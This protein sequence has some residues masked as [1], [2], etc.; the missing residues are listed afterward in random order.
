MEHFRANLIAAY[1]HNVVNNGVN[2]FERIN[3]VK[4]N[5]RENIKYRIT[6]LAKNC[7]LVEYI[8]I[9]QIN[10]MFCLHSTGT[11]YIWF[12][13]GPIYT[14]VIEFTARNYLGLKK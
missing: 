1:I 3:V 8:C 2:N 4:I 12:K 7:H 11:N 6:A 5:D 9:K 10:K 14:G 13:D